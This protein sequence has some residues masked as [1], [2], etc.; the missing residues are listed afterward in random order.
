MKTVDI[1]INCEFLKMDF[2][3]LRILSKYARMTQFQETI[4][5]KAGNWLFSKLLEK[6]YSN[7]IL[8]LLLKNEINYLENL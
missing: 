3:Y 4:V 1:N 5:H 6:N 8:H 7:S 2:E